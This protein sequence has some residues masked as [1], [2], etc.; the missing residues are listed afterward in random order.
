MKKGRFT[1]EQIGRAFRHV[2]VRTPPVRLCQ[3]LG[4]SEQSIYRGKR[5]FAGM[6]VAELRRVRDENRKLEQLAADL[7][8]ASLM[9]EE[10]AL[11]KD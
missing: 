4:V 10:G 7:T 5:R 11:R 2:R 6:G 9:L 1:E 8:L 3:R